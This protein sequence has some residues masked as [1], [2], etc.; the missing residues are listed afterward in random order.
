MTRTE[1]TF[2]PHVQTINMAVSAALGTVIGWCL[3]V[4]V[5]GGTDVASDRHSTVGLSTFELL[6]I[7]VAIVA[8]IALAGWISM[9]RR[10]LHHD[11]RRDDP[12]D[13]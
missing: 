5:A 7:A 6:G 3:V 2:T 12:A 4:I 11:H 9:R 13:A 8:L 1:N 10:G